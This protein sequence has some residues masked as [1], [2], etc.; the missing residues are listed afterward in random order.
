MCDCAWSLTNANLR[1]I[2]T[3]L[4]IIHL[5]IIHLEIIQLGVIASYYSESRCG[6][7]LNRQSGD[8]RRFFASFPSFFILFFILFFFLWTLIDSISM[9]VLAFLFFFFCVF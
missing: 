3:H 7:A 1:R 2:Y 4:E 9:L 5:E 8:L 6:R